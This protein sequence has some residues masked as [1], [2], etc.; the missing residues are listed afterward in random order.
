VSRR[1]VGLGAWCEF[2]PEDESTASPGAVSFAIA[3][4]A[5]LDDGRRVTLHAGERGFSSW[6]PPSHSGHPLRHMSAEAIRAGVL[7]TVLPDDDDT[8]DQ[9]PYEWFAALLQQ[10]AITVSA[11]DLRSVPYEVRLSEGLQQLLDTR[12]DSSKD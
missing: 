5:T 3:E 10:R 6:G 7:T 4:S 1:V 2:V 12:R 9:H 8:T 11:D